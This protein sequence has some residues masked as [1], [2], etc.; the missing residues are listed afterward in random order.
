MGIGGLIE[1]TVLQSCRHLYFCPYEG[2]SCFVCVMLMDYFS[3]LLSDAG[4]MV[5]KL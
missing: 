2:K 4:Y 1:G 3:V 5:G